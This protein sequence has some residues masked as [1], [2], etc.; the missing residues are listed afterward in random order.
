MAGHLARLDRADGWD[1]LVAANGDASIAKPKPTLYLRALELL[2][3]ASAEAVAIEDSPNG[4]LA[5]KAAGLY[6]VAVPNPVT[7]GLDLS[8]ADVVVDALTDLPLD[9]LLTLADGR[10]R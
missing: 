3:I 8:A 4:V 1:C 5:A 6:C 10:A 7:A 2:G 9:E